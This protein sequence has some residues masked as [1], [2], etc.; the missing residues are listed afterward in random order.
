VSSGWITS[1][2][3]GAIVKESKQGHNMPCCLSYTRKATLQNPF[4]L[5]QLLGL[6]LRW[7]DANIQPPPP[8]T[9]PTLTSSYGAFS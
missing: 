7:K 3:A 5:R 9:G 8:P 1:L 2:Q 6:G 4:K